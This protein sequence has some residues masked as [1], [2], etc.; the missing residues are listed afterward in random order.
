MVVLFFFFVIVVFEILRWGYLFK[1]CIEGY[2]KGKKYN[3]L[4]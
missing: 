4:I 3:L 2:N 1:D